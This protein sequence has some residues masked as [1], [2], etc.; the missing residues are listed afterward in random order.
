MRL[1]LLLLL[2]AITLIGSSARGAVVLTGAALSGPQNVQQ[3]NNT[4]ISAG[5]TDAGPLLAGAYALDSHGTATVLPSPSNFSLLQFQGLAATSLSTEI[6]QYNHLEAYTSYFGSFT[7]TGGPAPYS[8]ALS[9]SSDGTASGEAGGYAVVTVH[10]TD[11]N[12]QPIG[13]QLDGASGTSAFSASGVLAPGSY[14][15]SL[16]VDSYSFTGLHQPGSTESSVSLNYQLAV[17]SSVPELSSILIWGM[18]LGVI[19]GIT[20]LRRS[21]EHE[22]G[23][24]S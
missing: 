18:T 6:T 24:S 1:K 20:L 19:G 21:P 14:G 10:L 11:A 15:F 13:P 3:G 8:I 16:T 23:H 12:A 2:T 17:L 5:V 9:F 22:S 7:V 4:V